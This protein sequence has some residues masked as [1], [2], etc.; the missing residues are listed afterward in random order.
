MHLHRNLPLFLL[1]L[2]LFAGCSEPSLQ[3]SAQIPTPA[4]LPTLAPTPSNTP[5]DSPTA[6][7]T[8]TPSATL[9]P[10]IEPT[11]TQTPSP[12]AALTQAADIGATNAMLLETLYIVQT[13]S[14]ATFTETPSNT[15]TPSATPTRTPSNTP[16][17]VIAAT[18]SLF[19]ARET[20]HLRT[21]ASRLC[22]SV[23]QVRAGEAMMVT[24][25][26]SG[27]AVEASNTTWYRVDHQ[28]RQVFAY[29]DLLTS[30]P[31]PP[32]TAP[33]VQ[34]PTTAPV[35]ISPLQTCPG[36]TF[37]CGMLTCEQARACL[38]AGNDSLDQDGDGVPCESICTGDSLSPPQTCPSLTATCNSLTCDQAKAC[39]AAGN[40]S[41]DGNNNG[42][43]CDSICGG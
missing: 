27:E 37:T 25:R 40:D 35:F 16:D 8:L 14:I 13:I 42:I 4:V 1:L 3:Q 43:P 29:S 26:M 22:E 24:G 6:T 36:Q 21:C 9:S 33:L 5:T 17:P 10:T 39:F 38:I 20:V 28:G 30:Q 34:P 11:F 31:M 19:F 15:P 12:D 23:A 7:A 18:P 32:T 41:L 2:M